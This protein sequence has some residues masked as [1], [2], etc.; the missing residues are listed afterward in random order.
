MPALS[1]LIWLP[2]A[3]G[4]L[5]ALLPC[6]PSSTCACQPELGVRPTQ[7]SGALPGL[8]AL[9]GTVAALGLAIAYIVQYGPGS[10]G[11]KDVTDIVWI[12][13]LGIHYKLGVSGLNVLLVGLTD[14]PV[15]RRDP[16]GKFAHLGAARASSTST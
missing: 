10:H 3:C 4:L 7:A 15:L 16:G 5:G 11:L 1:I 14:A 13:E 9:A 12:S 8:L 6:R 2:A